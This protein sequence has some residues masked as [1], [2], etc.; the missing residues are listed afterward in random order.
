[1]KNE[2]IIQEILNRYKYLYQNKELILSLCIDEKIR[3]NYYK[4]SIKEWKK[5]LKLM[6]KQKNKEIIELINIIIEQDKI[7]L[8]TPYPYLMNEIHQELISNFEEFLFNNIPIENTKLYQIIENI[9]L[10][11]EKLNLS[12][13]KIN[14]LLERRN[15][16]KFLCNKNCLTVWRILTYVRNKHK[17]NQAV[18]DALDKYYNIDRYI[19]TGINW[20]SGYKL[21]N[22]DIINNE[23]HLNNVPTNV[24]CNEVKTPYENSMIIFEY[25]GNEYEQEDDYY[26]FE[27]SLEF[28]N[29]PQ[30]Y[31]NLTTFMTKINQIE[32]I[33]ENDKNKLYQEIYQKPKTKKYKL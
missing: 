18:L 27:W 10:D 20:I 1:M 11:E 12:Q 24:L 7:A 15:H 33:S 6:K 23:Q 3:T 9:K 31:Q 13:N 29:T 22:E 5:H 25:E 19:L 17:D 16:N 32:N 2:L 14:A 8:I 4:K 30:N 26:A 28:E 21:L